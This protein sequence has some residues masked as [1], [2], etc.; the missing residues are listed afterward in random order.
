[1]M[2]TL[3]VEL[4]RLEINRLIL[5]D[6]LLGADAELAFH[7]LYYGIWASKLRYFEIVVK[8]NEYLELPLNQIG[9]LKE[10]HIRI[11]RLEYSIFSR[12]G[13]NQIIF[14][15]NALP[16]ALEK[17]SVCLVFNAIDQK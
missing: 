3:S 16:E 2:Q 12:I 4:Q 10:S 17:L 11:F 5:F 13:V 1:M 7:Q 9:I 15:I 6:P 14:I 8:C